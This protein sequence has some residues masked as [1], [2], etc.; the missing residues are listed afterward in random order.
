MQYPDQGPEAFPTDDTSH[1][2]HSPSMHCN[3]NET[4]YIIA[5]G[6]SQSN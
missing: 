2:L 1:I 5:K 6:M 3:A 4:C